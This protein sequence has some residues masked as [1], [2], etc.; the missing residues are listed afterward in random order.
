MKTLLQIAGL[1]MILHGALCVVALRT[2]HSPEIETQ[3]FAV[4][5]RLFGTPQVI[6]LM[7]VRYYWPFVS[8]PR[9]ARMLTSRVRA[10]IL[11]ARL[12][13]LC[14]LC[15]LLGFLATAFVEAGR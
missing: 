5:N 11:A 4:P 9:E 3:L 2:I 15:A 14:C 13:G 8:L 12:T 10:I 7:R 6:R 1:A